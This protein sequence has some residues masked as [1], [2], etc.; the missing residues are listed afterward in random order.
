[1]GLSA[2]MNKQDDSLTA[3]IEW[4]YAGNS[5]EILHFQTLIHAD[6]EVVHN[7]TSEHNTNVTSCIVP[8]GRTN[9]SAS[10]EAIGRCG[11]HRMNKSMYIA[12]EHINTESLSH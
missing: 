2:T 3:Y 1:M 10:V 6:N 7:K 12:S 5:F 4:D 8:S 11:G 9:Y